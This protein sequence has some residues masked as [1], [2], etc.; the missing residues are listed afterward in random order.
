MVK[1]KDNS[2]PCPLYP[3]IPQA[4]LPTPT[5]SSAS[6]DSP[7]PE[8]HTSRCLQGIFLIKIPSPASHCA[9]V[10]RV[11]WVQ[12]WSCFYKMEKFNIPFL[13]EYFQTSLL[14]GNQPPLGQVTSWSATLYLSWAQVKRVT[15]TWSS[16]NITLGTSKSASQRSENKTK[17]EATAKISKTNHLSQ[18]DFGEKAFP[19]L[20]EQYIWPLLSLPL[21]LQ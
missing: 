18:H 10:H 8:I 7:E 14:H 17:Q 20:M 5:A 19:N 3:S 2:L 13:K 16:L 15:K 6:L 12:S 1:K 9:S 21:A 4:T 11:F